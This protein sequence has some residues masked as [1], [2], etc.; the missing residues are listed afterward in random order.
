MQFALDENKNRIQPTKEING[1]CPCCNECLTAKMGEKNI[2]H[3]SHKGDTNCNYKPMTQWHYDWQNK[4]PEENREI[5]YIDKT[6]GEKHVAD[7]SINGYI[8]EFQHSSISIEE[9][10]SRCEFYINKLRK[11]L[12]WVFDYNDKSIELSSF[13]VFHPFKLRKIKLRKNFISDLYNNYNNLLYIYEDKNILNIQLVDNLIFQD[14]KINFNYKHFIN[15]IM[16]DCYNVQLYI[17]KDNVYR[18]KYIEML[19]KNNKIKEDEIKEIEEKAL[20]NK[21]QEYFNKNQDILLMRKKELEAK[22]LELQDQIDRLKII[23]DELTNT[24]F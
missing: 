17:Y 24:V 8:F 14:L 20:K 18:K 7:V 23:I 13:E 11:K 15:K 3:W 4:F 22:N 1:Y 5:I 2:H 19:Y 6:T 16:T 21:W 9:F 12:I 10:K